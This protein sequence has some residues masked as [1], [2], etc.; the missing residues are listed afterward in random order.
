MTLIKA[1]MADG[2][3]GEVVFISHC[4]LNTNARYLGGSERS[5][6]VD[7]LARGYLESGVG[8]CQMPC[9]ERRAWGGVLKPY[10]WLGLGLGKTPLASLAFRIFVLMTR[11]RYRRYA[12]EAVREI[13]DYVRSGCTVRGILGIDGSPTCGVQKRLGMER[14]FA[15]FGG[16]S[17]QNLDRTALN[18]ALYG[19]CQ[20]DGPG[21]FI[22]ALKEELKRRKLGVPITAY[23][24]VNEIQ[25]GLKR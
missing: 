9:P 23:D 20:E 2:R 22:S 4:I 13:A 18:T 7:E 25:G 12:R 5:G 6:S 14:C 8:I 11:A 17:L 24:L 15:L 1:R 16:T 10:L 21:L 19:T 3:K